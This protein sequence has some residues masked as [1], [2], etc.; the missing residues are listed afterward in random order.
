MVGRWS[1]CSTGAIQT[2]SGLCAA[3]AKAG[4]LGKTA[5]SSRRRVWVVIR[6]C[7][8]RRPAIWSVGSRG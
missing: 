1:T 3:A 4:C 8:D 7:G 2:K 6:D 5:R